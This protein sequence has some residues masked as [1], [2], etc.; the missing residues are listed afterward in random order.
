MRLF[1]E[2]VRGDRCQSD[3]TLKVESCRSWG[4][5]QRTSERER[6]NIRRSLW[7][8]HHKCNHIMTSFAGCCLINVLV[9]WR[10]MMRCSTVRLSKPR[11]LIYLHPWL[12][13]RFFFFLNVCCSWWSLPTV[14]RS[15]NHKHHKQKQKWSSDLL[16]LS[17]RLTM[18]ITTQEMLQRVGFSFFFSLFFFYN[19]APFK[20]R[21]LRKL[22][23]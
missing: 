2:G 17:G 6:E 3:R 16:L 11:S 23:T 1:L 21:Y 19:Q 14:K 8:K 22:F 20:A 9:A 7:Y 12:V 10:L 15:F 18:K 13:L 5:R 4:E